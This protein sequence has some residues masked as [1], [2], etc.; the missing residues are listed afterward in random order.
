MKKILTGLIIC[1]PLIAFMSF[2]NIRL[3]IESKVIIIFLIGIIASYYQADY[4]PLKGDNSDVDK[5]TVLHIIWSVYISQALALLEAF[6]LN[7]DR[8]FQYDA[9]S[10]FFLSVALFGLFFRSWAYISLGKFFTMHLQTKDDQVLIE[11]G[12]YRFLR[13]P[14]YTGAFLTYT[15]IP[16]FLG[17]YRAALI[18]ALLL[19][20]AF[21]R[22]IIQEEKMLESH[23]GDKYRVFCSKRARLVPFIW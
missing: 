16:L 9:L 8:A 19:L 12:P 5:G 3:L 13:H 4:N 10:I 11:N 6:F 1:I 15:F 2:I 7:R 18:S 21:Y 17:S 14:S 22:R 20:L 23:M